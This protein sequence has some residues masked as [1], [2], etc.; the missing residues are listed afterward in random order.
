[1]RHINTT[2]IVEKVAAMCMNA[3]YHLGNDV[4]E[5]LKIA[6]NKE[7]SLTGQKIL[8]HIIENAEV[9]NKEVFPLCQDTG[10]AVFFVEL[11]HD[12]HIVGNELKQA[13]YD[14]VRKGYKDGYLRN[15]IV[16]DPLQR[17]NTGDNT[18]AVVWIDTVPGDKI[19][20]HMAPKGGGSENMSFVRMLKPSQGRQGVIDFVIEQVSQAGGNPC[21][22][23]IIGVG[24]GG[25]FEKCAW[26]AKKSLL[27]KVG[28]HHPDPFY[29]AMENEILRKVNETGI[30]PMGFGGTTTALDVHIETFPCHI[31]SLPVA[32]NIQCHSARHQTI[33][34]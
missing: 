27:R 22:P 24:I 19:T 25:T 16:G 18:P 15:S 4:R 1:M 12:V 2:E 8:S 30:G 26:L 23:G 13:I 34:I 10:Y 6:L 3:N 29:A 9:A 21:P 5:A 28:E 14:G 31:A 17:V 7:E 11:G 33:T 32:V 20:I